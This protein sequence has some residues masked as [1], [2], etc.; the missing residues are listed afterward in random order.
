M[1]WVETVNDV[2]FCVQKRFR[3]VTQEYYIVIVV[4]WLKIA[5]I[6]LG[7]GFYGIAKMQWY[8]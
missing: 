1:W 5:V 4:G 3:K 2:K 8:L 6:F 7:L